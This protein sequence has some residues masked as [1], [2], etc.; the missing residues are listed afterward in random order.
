M[1]NVSGMNIVVMALP[2]EVVSMG[3]QYRRTATELC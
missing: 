2:T 3:I 1:S